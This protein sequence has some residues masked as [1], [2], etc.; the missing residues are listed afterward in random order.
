[1]AMKQRT[2]GR[3][4]MRVS[5]L[6]FGC[7]G[8]TGAYGALAEAVEPV[9]LVHAAIDAGYTLFDTAPIYGGGSNE[10][11][12]GRAVQGKREQVV[13][14]TKFGLVLKD[15]RIDATDSSPAAVVA[16]VEASLAQLKTDYIDILFQHR[17]DPAVPI[18]ETVGAMARLV[19]Q[20]KVRYL[21]LSEASAATLRR[22]HAVHP[23]TALQS[24]YSLLERGLEA[25]LL[26]LTREL[27]IG[28]MPFSPL[29]R[30]LVAGTPRP[31]QERDRSDYR[32]LDPRYQGE[33]YERNMALVRG[34]GEIAQGL[35]FA[36]S[37]V[38]LAWLLQ[39]EDDL[40]PLVG[41]TRL[42]TLEINRI[43]TEITLPCDVVQKLDALFA[44]DAVSGERYPASMMRFVD[45]EQ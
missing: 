14:S 38:A 25:R 22:A 32:R 2:L 18:E 12:L 8:L 39:R 13:L 42:A 23:I 30:G 41:I 36:A 7:M 27:G 3:Q 5:A 21:G 43:A 34:L 37:Q 29:G 26:P 9:R 24:E 45:P 28:L 31:A 16:S 44:P 35:G 11:L 4:G 17:V 19:E 40:A 6:G 1:M 10:A 15:G 20:G 33:N